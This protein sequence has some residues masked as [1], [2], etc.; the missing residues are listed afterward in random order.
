[1]Q[2]GRV[3]PY[4]TTTADRCPERHP[5]FKDVCRH[6]VGH[7]GLHGTF[8]DRQFVTVDVELVIPV[9]AVW[10]FD[11]TLKPKR[12]AQPDPNDHGEPDW[13]TYS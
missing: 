6:T 13:A 11:A 4:D 7:D 2:D 9:D 5:G 1:M 10:T 3:R 8:A 12:T